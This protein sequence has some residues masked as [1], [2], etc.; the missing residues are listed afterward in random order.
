[1][2][3]DINLQWLRAKGDY[4]QQT[5]PKLNQTSPAVKGVSVLNCASGLPN[6]SLT[7]YYVH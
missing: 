7:E 2:Q 3:G 5:V 6:T 1:M 4:W